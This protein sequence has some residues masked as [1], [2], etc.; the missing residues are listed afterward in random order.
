[1]SCTVAGCTS[2]VRNR[3]LCS[4]HYYAERRGVEDLG[5]WSPRPRGAP[6]AGRA[7]TFAGCDLPVKSKDL[8]N[9]HYAQQ[10]RGITLRPIHRASGGWT[11]GWKNPEGYVLLFRVTEGKRQTRSEHR[12]VMEQ[13]LGR[14]LEKGETVHHIN[15]VRD[16]N[17]IENLELWSTR[18]PKGQR[19]EDKVKWAKELLSKYD[20]DALA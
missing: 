2:R 8:C 16:D 18:Q 9:S 4:S 13:H 11:N 17:R 15:G 1:M 12:V 6:V 5:N 19:V 3:G 10:Q 7:C 20:P 14:E